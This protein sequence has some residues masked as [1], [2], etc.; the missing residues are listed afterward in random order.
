MLVSHVRYQHLYSSELSCSFSTELAVSPANAPIIV[1]QQL[2]P[3][4]FV[5]LRRLYLPVSPSPPAH[6]PISCLLR[7]FLSRD[8]PHHTTSVRFAAIRLHPR[9]NSPRPQSPRHRP[10]SHPTTLMVS[11]CSLLHLHLPFTHCSHLV[12]T[13]PL[14]LF[15]NRC[16]A[17]GAETERRN[18]KH[19]TT[20]ASQKTREGH[21]KRQ[22][23]DRAYTERTEWRYEYQRRQVADRRDGQHTRAHG[24]NLLSSSTC[25]TL[26]LALTLFCLLSPTRY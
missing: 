13:T 14:L 21:R 4:C 11:D 10:T 25:F 17:R 20:D 12:A 15:C 26:S 6:L 7:A 1:V 5:S 22:V 8:N 18:T 19:K 16:R 3:A 9:S 23:N 2:A 24:D